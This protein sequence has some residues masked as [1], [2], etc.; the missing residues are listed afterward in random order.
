MF[1]LL[2]PVIV[3]TTMVV[4]LV[5][6]SRQCAES[7][8]ALCAE[9]DAGDAFFEW[10]TRNPG[11]YVGLSEEGRMLV[12]RWLHAHDW[13]QRTH[14]FIDGTE[15]REW[16]E[17]FLDDFPPKSPKRLPN[18]KKSVR[19]GTLSFYT[20]TGIKY[21]VYYPPRD[22]PFGAFFIKVRHTYSI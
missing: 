8:A 15:R 2:F 12:G 16:I 20:L 11:V 1:V 6:H 22:C 4:F 14:T 3:A 5:R 17:S 9:C 7:H 21:L 13:F 18:G 10:S 19:R